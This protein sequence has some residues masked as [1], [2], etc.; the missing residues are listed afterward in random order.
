[1]SVDPS[2]YR[3]ALGHFCTGVTVITAEADGRAR[4]MTASAFTSVSLRPALVLVCIGETARINPVIGASGRYGVSILSSAQETVS[5]RF[6]RPAGTDP[7]FSFE[8]WHGLPVVP[9]ALVHLAVS[10]VAAFPQGDHI[11]HVGEVE[12]CR[13]GSGEPLIYYRGG[14]QRRSA[15]P[16]S[17]AM[18]KDADGG[19]P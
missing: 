9:D 18:R 12:E 11:I 5:D 17:W 3:A 16:S 13:L 19:S 14:Y 4:A 1:M 10:V 6:G 2:T 15:G 8:R 7:E